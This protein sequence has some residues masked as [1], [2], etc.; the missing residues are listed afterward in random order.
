M[1]GGFII[2]KDI[3]FNTGEL[4]VVVKELKCK[5][6][7]EINDE[8]YNGRSKT[9]ARKKFHEKLCYL[10]G[11]VADLIGVK[12]ITI[13]DNTTFGL[14]VVLNG[15]KFNAGD[16]V[17]TTSMEHIASISP[18]I[19]L[20]NKKGIII[21]EYKVG[22]GFNLKQLEKLITFKTKMIVISHIFWKTGEVIPIRKV[23]DLAHKNGLKVL[24]DGA[25]AVGSYPVDLQA[26][27]VDFYCFPAHK[28]LYGPE[29]LGFL[30]VRKNNQEELDVIFSGISTVQ[31]FNNF[32][33]YIIKDNGE[34]WELGTM[35]RPSISGM[36]SVL[37]YL[38]NT[39]KFENIYLK[40]LSLNK[41]LISLISDIPD[42]SI[43]TNNNYNICTLVLPNNV[44]SEEL[45]EYLER[46]CIFTKSIEDINAIRISLS[47]INNKSDIRYLIR[48]IRKYMEE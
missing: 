2:K 9:G 7:Q 22:G 38:T 10:R 47:F 8:F 4:S 39:I 40:T 20:K 14:N 15:M 43:C 21:K 23:I 44:S 42:I 24:V 3:Y 13:T 26:I 41:Y 33:D 37:E 28:W 12:E 46:Y 48:K 17:I 6:I 19:N 29:G 35:F 27:N 16:E 25:Q 11:Q 5:M 1:W 34:K 36:I 18:L 30:F 45:K 32:N 31:H